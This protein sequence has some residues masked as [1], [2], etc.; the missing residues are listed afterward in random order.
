MSRALGFL[1]QAL[2]Y[3]LFFLPLAYLSHEPAYRVLDE[4]MALLKLAVRHPG[5]IVG[6]CT[7]ATTPGQGMRPTTMTQATEVCPRA[8]S[9]LQLELVLDGETLYR[10]T[11][12]A[13]GLHSDGISSVYM[14]FEVP[15]GRHNL[16]LRM[17][18]DVAMEGYPWQFEQDIE[19]Q[20]AQVMVAN[21]KQGFRLQ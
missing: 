18:D 13:S 10:A 4:D 15:A 20:P 6:E 8:R 7:A 16:Q 11:V 12:P 19:L 21:F 2:C 14:Q 3:A 1:G 5:K 9:G 17:N